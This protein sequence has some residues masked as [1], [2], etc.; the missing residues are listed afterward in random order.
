MIT[1]LLSRSVSFHS[2][3]S[4]TKK[5]NHI[6]RLCPTGG[7][8]ITSFISFF[9]IISIYF[10]LCVGLVGW[11]ATLLLLLLH[12]RLLL[13]WTRD[14]H[15]YQAVSFAQTFVFLFLSV[16]NH[17][18]FVG[19]VFLWVLLSVCRSFLSKANVIICERGDS[20]RFGA[21]VF[22]FDML[23]GVLPFQLLCLSLITF[24]FLIRD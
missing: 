15:L 8:P 6:Y 11:L 19:S 18:F 20:L 24:R 16:I 14:N 12:R 3:H 1:F 9:I 5:E 2:L 17:F 4:L 7:I 23:I 22:S 13:T 10:F 21:F